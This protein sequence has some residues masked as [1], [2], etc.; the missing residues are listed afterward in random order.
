MSYTPLYLV[1]L[2]SYL[3]SVVIPKKTYFKGVGI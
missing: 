3:A 2:V 1:C